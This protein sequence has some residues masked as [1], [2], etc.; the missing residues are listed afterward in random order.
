MYVH[1]DDDEL[2][3]H[4]VKTEGHETPATWLL[5]ARLKRLMTGGLTLGCVRVRVQTTNIMLSQSSFCLRDQKKENKDSRATVSSKH[6]APTLTIR[7]RVEDDYPLNLSILI[8]GGKETNRDSLS[9]G[10]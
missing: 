4:S 8:S 9:K 6:H 3:C 2:L 1:Y 10:D 7:P 5:V